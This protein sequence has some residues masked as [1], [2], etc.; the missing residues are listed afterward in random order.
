M[1]Q[2]SLPITLTPACT[3]STW[4]HTLFGFNSYNTL[5]SYVLRN[6]K[7]VILL[8]SLRETDAIDQSI[9]EQKKPEVIAFYN[10][11]K[12][13]VDTADQMCYIFSVS[14]NIRRWS[15]V[16]F[17]LLSEHYRNK[18]PRDFE[19]EWTGATKKKNISQNF[20]STTCDLT[21]STAKSEYKKNAESAANSV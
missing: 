3:D 21:T 15:M 9:G 20:V 13:E 11:S 16:F 14:R 4:L 2:S 5:V 18:F 8:S 7:K 6:W 10:N 17:F 12:A 1:L 19:W